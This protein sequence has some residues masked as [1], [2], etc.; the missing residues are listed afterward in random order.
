MIA[1]RR[2]G[3][4]TNGLWPAGQSHQHPITT[5]LILLKSGWVVG[6]GPWSTRTRFRGRWRGMG[7]YLLDMREAIRGEW[8][9]EGVFM[10]EVA[11]DRVSI[12]R[13]IEAAT[14]AHVRHVV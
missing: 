2:P 8:R 5:H 1:P 3:S 9:I 10:T 6:R 7:T 12:L 13:R 11:M 4:Q 14:R